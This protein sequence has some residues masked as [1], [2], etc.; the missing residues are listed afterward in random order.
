VGNDRLIVTSKDGQP[1]QE[2]A[3]SQAREEDNFRRVIYAQGWWIVVGND[4]RMDKHEGSVESAKLA[5]NTFL[6]F[7][8][9]CMTLLPLRTAGLSRWETMG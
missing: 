3:L 6:T 9:T 2:Y 7:R 4:G 1:W 5:G 8:K